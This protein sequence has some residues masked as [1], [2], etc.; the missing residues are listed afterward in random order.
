MIYIQKVPTLNL[1]CVTGHRDGGFFSRPSS[2]PPAKYP[3]IALN[4]LIAVPFYRVR[5]KHMMVF[6]IK[7]IFRKSVKFFIKIGRYRG[8]KSLARPGRKQASAAEYFDVHIS[9]L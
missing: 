7:K 5:Q 1:N 2:D 6:E 4:W 3:V 9:Y 8:G